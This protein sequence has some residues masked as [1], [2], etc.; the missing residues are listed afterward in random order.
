[1]QL[2]MWLYN[3]PKSRCKALQLTQVDDLS[4]PQRRYAWVTPLFMLADFFFFFRCIIVHFRLSSLSIEESLLLSGRLLF[5]FS[6]P[7]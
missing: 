2:L 7:L 5:H 4:D 3:D 6:F 1:M